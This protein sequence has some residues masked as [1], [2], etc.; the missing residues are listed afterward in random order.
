MLRKKKLKEGE[1]ML[2]IDKNTRMLRDS[3]RRLSYHNK[4]V[5]HMCRPTR[6][7]Y[8]ILHFC[9]QLSQKTTHSMNRGKFKCL[10]DRRDAFC[11][12]AQIILSWVRIQV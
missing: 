1:R 5:L 4:N 9:V 8:F 2:F 6:E 3:E 10:H 11:H 7:V 12:A